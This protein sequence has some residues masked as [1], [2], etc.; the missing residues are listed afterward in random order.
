M[1]VITLSG[2]DLPE[3]VEICEQ[4][5]EPKARNEV[6]LEKGSEGIPTSLGMERETTEEKES[7]KL[8]NNWKLIK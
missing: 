1:E 4:Y 8:Q 2:Y 6:G 3:K 7:L 5:L